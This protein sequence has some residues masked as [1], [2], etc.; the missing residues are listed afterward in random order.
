MEHVEG[1]GRLL[2]ASIAAWCTLWYGAY[3]FAAIAR[4]GL[5]DRPVPL[6]M[7]ALALACLWILAQRRPMPMALLC[8]IALPLFGNHP[9]GRLMELV[10]LPLAATA[11]GMVRQARRWDRPPP[12]GPIWLAAALYVACALVAI[13]PSIPGIMVRAAQLNHWPTTAMEALTAPEDNPLYAVSSLAGVTLAA[14][15]A[16]ALA[17]RGQR[18]LAS[19]I[20]ALV[21][22]FFIVVAIGILDYHGVI[23]V[24][25]YFYWVDPRKPDLSGFQS[26]FWNPGWFAWYF[27]MA[28]ALGLGYLW[29]AKGVERIIVGALLAIAYV[30]F[31]RNP[32][33]GGLIAVHVCLAV[34]AA[35]LFVTGGERSRF[36]RLMPLAAAALIA[37]V[38]GAYA[39]G[40]IPR[41]LG[42]SLFRLVEVPEETA[43]SNTVR[44][45]L[46]RV[47]LDMSGD[48][49]VFGIGEGSFGWRFE[50]YAPPGTSLYTPLHGDAHNTWLQLLA[51]RGI[52][53][54]ASLL[55]LISAVGLALRR[56]W[57]EPDET[58]QAVP[59]D[60]HR[61]A[62]IGVGLSLIG[63]LVYS[64]VQAMFYLQSIQILFW[65]LVA[66][67]SISAGPPR[68]PAPWRLPRAAV[69]ALIVVA[70]I[71]QGV[72]AAPL[73]ERAVDAIAREPRGVYPVERSASEPAAWRWTTG[74]AAICLAPAGPVMRLTLS[75]ADPRLDEYPRDI[76][77]KIDGQVVD[78]FSVPGPEGVVRTV[79]L[80]PGPRLSE[81]SGEFGQ[82]THR[83]GEL[84][85]TVEVD[86]R[87]S[88]LTAGLGDDPRTLGVQIFEPEYVQNPE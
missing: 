60:V 48:A 3:A 85:L 54:V 73:L 80:P 88:P 45:R 67:A 7:A 72:I 24:A 37:A 46:W 64:T 52:A 40:V 23:D 9:G 56:A 32:Q 26:I 35:V 2:G 76:T 86:R 79:M 22:T 12:S 4:A 25:R 47:A 43:T 74:D 57:R 30:Y 82:C 6:A 1:K 27:T 63:F 44:A 15:W 11:V 61:G 71:V 55:L 53:G 10:N 18:F 87:W 59:L 38:T 39:V 29:R 21:Y 65:F 78:M 33:R 49:P 13:V 14:A 19:S 16:A 75:T 5:L 68:T 51:T 77:L 50:E 66:A 58:G 8:L 28:F 83:P 17:W 34:A 70:L 69:V 31:F 62:V 41:E 84:R 42:S 81:P 20:P 36:R